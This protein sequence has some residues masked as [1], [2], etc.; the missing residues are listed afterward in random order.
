MIPTIRGVVFCI[1]GLA[2]SLSDLKRGRIPH[3]WSVT[4]G[5]LLIITAPAAVDPLSLLWAAVVMG[6]F[7]LATAGRLGGGDVSF[8]LFLS[9]YLPRRALSA[10]LITGACLFLI[11]HSS[12]KE[13][14]KIRRQGHPFTPFLFVAA[15]AVLALAA[16]QTAYPEDRSRIVEVEFRDQPIREMLLV[17]AK[18]TGRS[19]IPDETVDGHASYLFSDISVDEAL[20]G[21]ADAYGLFL[22]ERPGGITVVSR[23]KAEAVGAGEVAVE[24]IDAP[25]EALLRQLSAL[26]NTPLR[27]DQVDGLR[28]TFRSPPMPLPAL[29]EALLAPLPLVLEERDAYLLLRPI[30]SD[31]AGSPQNVSPDR[32]GSSQESFVPWDAASGHDAASDD[33][34][35]PGGSTFPPE[36]GGFALT[37]EGRGLWNLE[38]REAEFRSLVAGLYAEAGGS[39]VISSGGSIIMRDLMLREMELSTILDRVLEEA[40]AVT[41][42]REGTTVL[43]AGAEAPDV[44]AEVRLSRLPVR[45]LEELLQGEGGRG[46]AVLRDEGRNT[47]VLRGSSSRIGETVGLIATLDGGSGEALPFIRYPLRHSTAD[48]LIP[49]LPESL[50]GFAIFASPDGSS[51]IARLPEGP[52]EE[53][54]AFVDLFDQRQAPRFYALTAIRA[55]HLAERFGGVPSLPQL[56]P[57]PD[58]RG[59]MAAGT[60]GEIA[61]L[62]RLLLR[63]DRPRRQIRYDLLILRNMEREGSSW[64][65]GAEVSGDPA[66]GAVSLT[67]VF[68]Q[69]LS[70]RF[71]ALSL[72]GYRVAGA[73]SRGLSEHSSQ[74]L[75]DT[76]IYGLDGAE[77]HF[78][79]TQTYRYRDLAYDEEESEVLPTGVTREIASGITLYVQGEVVKGDQVRMEITAEYSRQGVHLSDGTSPPSTTE[80]RVETVV[81]TA[82]GEPIILAGLMQ[83]EKEEQSRPVPLL[84]R[85]PL[86][87]R[88]FAPGTEDMENSELIIYLVPHI[89]ALEE[90][91]F[92]ATVEE[93][94]RELRKEEG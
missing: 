90:L 60:S 92:P 5:V 27:W 89:E 39:Y 48:E 87:G 94:I 3:L 36:G 79:N 91:G 74:L 72:L 21:F 1:V 45:A 30:S 49:A 50:E 43:F 37:A 46:V 71:D 67:G 76:T 6:S 80:K 2:A 54:R 35:R 78:T 63:I 83:Q 70:L 62:E 57:T 11:V 68:D 13:R 29:L 47:V 42:V 10:T 23:F 19:I 12:P 86:L 8:S 59:V 88:L 41:E 25:L 58:G 14:L 4:G 32:S 16:P 44:E 55:E 22:D 51:L 61:N 34:P 81:R 31:R 93:L 18:A 66:S 53:L 82:A 56:F 85:L 84:S 33:Y 26:S 7:Y 75:A 73:I 69:L 24:A 40:G 17:M 52:R 28:T 64:E 15:L 38:V 9:T 20:V 65:L 77:V